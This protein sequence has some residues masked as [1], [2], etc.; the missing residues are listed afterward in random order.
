[1]TIEPTILPDVSYD[2][3]WCRVDLSRVPHIRTRPN[4]VS[5][6]TVS[7]GPFGA[8]NRKSRLRIST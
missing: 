8:R 2:P 3:D 1:M 5:P 4:C 6:V 7:I